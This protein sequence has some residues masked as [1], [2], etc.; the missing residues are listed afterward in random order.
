MKEFD[1]VYSFIQGGFT[2][3]YFVI[4]LKKSRI[5]LINGFKLNIIK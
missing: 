3:I 4:E 5:G 2:K 1:S